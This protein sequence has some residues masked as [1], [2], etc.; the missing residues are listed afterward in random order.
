MKIKIMMI[1]SL[2]IFQPVLASN[3]TETIQFLGVANGQVVGN[4]L[5]RVTRTPVDPTLFR[6]KSPD[7]LPR[8]LVIRNAESRQAAGG[9]ANIKIKHLSS[10]GR[11]IF[12]NLKAA[13]I[14]D[15]SKVTINANQKGDD[16]IITV[17]AAFQQVE[18]RN[19]TVVEIE[20]PAN[21]RGNLHIPVEIEGLNIN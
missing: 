17:P 2:S 7:L 4:S 5:V 21:Y 15:G 12:L 1:A 9:L 8:E 18:L 10:D 3:I 16:L 11:H 20:V 6:I 13:L 19:E 14:V